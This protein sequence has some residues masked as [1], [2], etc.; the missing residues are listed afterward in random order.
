MIRSWLAALFCAI[1]ACETRAADLQQPGM[2][3]GAAT[4]EFSDPAVL[5][6]PAQNELVPLGQRGFAA[7]DGSVRKMKSPTLRNG[8]AGI[9]L[10]Q[11]P[12]VQAPLEPVVPPS[13]LAPNN[14]LPPPSRL[15]GLPALP[16]PFSG[17]PKPSPEVQR[18]FDRFIERKIDPQETLDLVIGRP[19]VL[20]LAQA[21]KRV[22]IPDEDV[23]T[24]HALSERELAVIG[25]QVGS[26][27]LNL[28]FTD[29]Q[30]PNN[31]RVLSYL[32]RVI[33]DPE[34]KAR[35]ERVYEALAAEINRD[36]PDSHVELSLVGDKLVVRGEAKDMLESTQILMVLRANAPGNQG[37]GQQNQGSRAQNIPV[38]A[39]GMYPMN[40][41]SVDDQ[42]VADEMGVSAPG[43]PGVSSFVLQGSNNIINL[44][45]IP[46][47]QQVMLKVTVAEVN[48]NAAR[49]IGM[50]FEIMN[51]A[52]QVVFANF[53]GGLLAGTAASGAIPGGNL[54]AALDNGQ[55][56]LAI[57]AL[58]TLNLARSLAEPNLVTINGRPAF[59][60]AGGSFPVPT[61]IT[62]TVGST[63]GQGVQYIPVGVVLSFTPYITD[64]DRIRLSVQSQVTTVGSATVTVGTTAVPANVD[65][66]TFTTTVELREGQTLAVAGLLQN[67]MSS[68]A[69]RVPFFADL[70]FIGMLNG[71][72]Q[73]S[74]SEQEVVVLITPQLVHPL[75]H[76]EIAAMPLPGADVF[77]P[78]DLEFFL[79]N[80]L[81]SRRS[82]DNRGG[83]RTDFAR[84]IRY[85]HCQ[86]EYILGPHGR[87]Q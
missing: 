13:P 10:T 48:R 20:V 11:L 53:T 62:S 39:G 73:T 2:L 72:N 60:H 71:F 41:A 19:R 46:G 21:P 43:A 28:W 36:F 50:N 81:E 6:T 47:E 42:I 63:V 87:S 31:E 37:G 54:P 58:R 44:L 78:G 24:F 52:G 69:N 66:R 1:A 22:Q 59:F 3:P 4:V 7:I 38:G 61:A 33:P 26:T 85:E 34:A 55:I 70:P 76:E 68:S 86:D 84:Q 15:Q 74:S 82:Y 75:E 40:T 83:V 12:N 27:V 79:L 18:E 45:R 8:T 77:E 80:R 65:Q 9:K 56:P 16:A 57:Q 35:L 17:T 25:K 51:K 14:V 64:R 5:P 67:N 30:S 49:S 23:A 32:V 29:P